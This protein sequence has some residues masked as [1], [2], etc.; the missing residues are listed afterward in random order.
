[1]TDERGATESLGDILKRIHG[2]L[3]SDSL[4][5]TPE[6]WSSGDS[7]LAAQCSL[8]GGAQWLTRRVEEWRWEAVPCAC[9]VGVVTEEQRLHYAEFPRVPTPKTFDNFRS[10]DQAEAE[11]LRV[12]RQF[13]TEREHFILTLHGPNG[14]GKSHLLEA[15]GRALVQQGFWVKYSFVPDLLDDL[16]NSYDAEAER[17]FEWLY[18]HYAKLPEVLLLDDLGA[19]SDTNWAVEKLTRLVDYRY[20]NRLTMVVGTNLGLEEMAEKLTPRIADRIFDIGTR[21]A[22]VVSMQSPSFRTG[23]EWPPMSFFRRWRGGR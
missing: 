17:S 10:R 21:A 9:Q 5:S 4:S 23:K 20:R 6:T 22:L 2:K 13:V 15:V 19:E 16:R 1:M 11:A 18:E 3:P 8:C 7:P 14:G 12:A